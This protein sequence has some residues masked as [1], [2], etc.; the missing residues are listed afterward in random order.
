MYSL[1]REI[2]RKYTQ[3][4]NTLHGHLEFTQF[5]CKCLLFTSPGIP[6]LLLLSSSTTGSSTSNF[7]CQHFAKWNAMSGMLVFWRREKSCKRFKRRSIGP[8][9]DKNLVSLPF[10]NSAFLLQSFEHFYFYK[11]LLEAW[12]VANCEK[13]ISAELDGWMIH[14]ISSRGSRWDQDVESEREKEWKY[15]GIKHPH[16]Y[17][18]WGGRRRRSCYV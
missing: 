4:S 1:Y 9:G 2:Y 10:L 11:F 3:H 18:R 6:L 16:G 14:S 5:P 17:Q 7:Y 13:G 8:W 15:P 12:G